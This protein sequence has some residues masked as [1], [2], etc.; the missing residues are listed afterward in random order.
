[1]TKAHE[2][3]AIVSQFADSFKQHC[4]RLSSVKRFYNMR[5]TGIVN[6]HK[7]DKHDNLNKVN[8]I[9]NSDR[10]ELLRELEL[11]EGE[12]YKNLVEYK[13]A[14]R[15]CQTEEHYNN[16]TISLQFDKPV[17]RMYTKAIQARQVMMSDQIQQVNMTSSQTQIPS[18]RN[19]PDMDKSYLSPS[20]NRYSR[21]PSAILESFRESQ[22]IKSLDDDI[23]DHVI[24]IIDDD[25]VSEQIDDMFN[26]STDNVDKSP[27]NEA[28]HAF[29]KLVLSRCNQAM[30]TI[31]ILGVPRTP[32]H[33][34]SSPIN[35]KRNLI[36][37]PSAVSCASNKS[38]KLLKLPSGV[39]DDKPNFMGRK[40]ISLKGLKEIAQY[41]DEALQ[42]KNVEDLGKEKDNLKVVLKKLDEFIEHNKKNLTQLNK[43]ALHSK[44]KVL[45][46]VES[47]MIEFSEIQTK[48][49]QAIFEKESAQRN[50][51]AASHDVA[52]AGPTLDSITKIDVGVILK[53]NNKNNLMISE[54]N[55][56]L[57]KILVKNVN[58]EINKDN[59][60]SSKGTNLLNIISKVYKE[61][62]TMAAK[63][64]KL[65][66]G[67]PSTPLAI[68]FYKFLSMKI[69]NNNL[70]QKKYEAILGSIIANKNTSSINLFGKFLGITGSYDHRCLEI[71]IETLQQFKKVA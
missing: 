42:V 63:A 37:L 58:K 3:A 47:R 71:F 22:I 26:M 65:K 15:C 53:I 20:H 56:I 51:E 18:L 64:K 48:Y 23:D 60:F 9:K 45:E 50:I 33:F 25:D 28:S 39:F 5:L 66:R 11:E 57:K 4:S 36:R 67:F 34:S 10:N 38:G 59:T 7:R 30:K 17:M 12:E 44:K 54:A 8:M 62:I 21:R 49:Y 70:V 52:H 61:Y 40:S 69:S 27:P 14:D 6:Q 1:M 24:D 31:P 41:F 13:T 32:V 55:N 16:M 43:D 46:Q 2:G 68:Y 29:S 35:S 19:I